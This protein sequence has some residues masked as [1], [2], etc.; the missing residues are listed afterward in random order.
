MLD[1]LSAKLIHLKM[2][3]LQNCKKQPCEV[4]QAVVPSIYVEFGFET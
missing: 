4:N 2:Q 3:T 1:Q